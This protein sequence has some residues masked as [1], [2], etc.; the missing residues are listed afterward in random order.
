MKEDISISLQLLFLNDLLYRKVIDQT[1]YN[2]AIQKITAF[3]ISKDTRDTSVI[4]KSA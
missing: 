4:R 1:I 2:K 3:S